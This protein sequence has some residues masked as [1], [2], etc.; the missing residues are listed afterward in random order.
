VWRSARD[1]RRRAGLMRR[2]ACQCRRGWGARTTAAVARDG[3]THPRSCARPSACQAPSATA[4]RQRDRGTS[5][6]GAPAR[7]PVC[8]CVCDA[9]VCVCVRARMCVCVCVCVCVCTCVS[10]GCTE[11]CTVA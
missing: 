7:S 9:E 8:V 1:K 5:R 6:S 2:R 10:S 3:H 4:Q 11:H